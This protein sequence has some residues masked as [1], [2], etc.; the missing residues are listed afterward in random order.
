LHG[1]SD[2]T[3]WE[4]QLQRINGDN[5]AITIGENNVFVVGANQAINVVSNTTLNLGYNV[6]LT[7]IATD[8]IAGMKTKCIFGLEADTVEAGLKRLSRN[9]PAR[10]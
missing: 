1:G 2:V 10:T 6:T 4:Y 5:T 3:Y 9:T 8:E 7:L